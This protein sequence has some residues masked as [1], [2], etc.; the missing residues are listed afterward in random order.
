[1]IERGPCRF[2]RHPS[3]AGALLALIGPGLSTGHIVAMRLTWLPALPAFIYRIHV[4][5]K[6][7]GQAF[8]E[9]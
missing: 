4:E 6:A 1:M 9:P 8:G 3:C 2:V 7:L 5:E